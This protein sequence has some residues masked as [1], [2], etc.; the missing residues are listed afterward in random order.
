MIN[1]MIIIK[2]SCEEE[3]RMRPKHL[4]LRCYAKKDEN[5]QWNAFCIDFGLAAQGESLEEVIIKMKDMIEE[6]LYDALV[7]D[8]V[9]FVEQL[10]SRRAPFKQIITY[11]Y[12]DLMFRIGMLKDGVHAL[13]KTPMPMV[14]QTNHK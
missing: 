9:E 11:H 1:P 14:L 13:F 10:L 8:D 2:I 4:L 3:R 7:G 6:Y 5:N 12:Y